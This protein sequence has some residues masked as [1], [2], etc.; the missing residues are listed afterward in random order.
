MMLD[1]ELHGALFLESP[2][3]AL[4]RGARRI[5]RPAGV[6]AAAGAF[7]RIMEQER[8]AEQ[9][10]VLHFGQNLSQAAFGGIFAVCQAGQLFNGDQRVLV[11]RI[12]VVLIRNNQA[13]DV[14]PFGKH[15]LQEI[16]L[17]HDAQRGGGMGKR[18]D[19][20]QRRP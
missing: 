5:D 13:K 19:A 2:L 17:V 4:H 14:A 15:G 10:Q 7:A 8:E 11:Y 20:V 9:S 6:I 1:Q 12:A 18:Q 16:R 3:D